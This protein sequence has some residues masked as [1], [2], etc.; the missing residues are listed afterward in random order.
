MLWIGHKCYMAH[1]LSW[2][3]KNKNKYVNTIKHKCKNTLCVNPDHLYSPLSDKTVLERFWNNV[4]I[5]G[6]DDCWEWK[7]TKYRYGYGCM[8]RMRNGKRIVDG[9]HRFSWEIANGRPPKKGLC[10]IHSCD[11]PPCVN[12]KHLREATHYENVQD[13]MRRGRHKCVPQRGEKNG[14]A[15]LTRKKVEKIRRLHNNGKWTHQKLSDKFG[16]SADTITNIINYKLW[17][18]D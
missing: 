17:T 1:K 7:G 12:P 15:K 16:V 8:K 4:D 2:E 14:M 13:M 3:L 5:K 9:T 10:I 18:A 6:P 11:N